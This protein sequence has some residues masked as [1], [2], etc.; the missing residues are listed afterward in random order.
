M[1]QPTRTGRR[2]AQ[3]GEGAAVEMLYRRPR[4]TARSHSRNPKR[5]LG[6]SRWCLISFLPLQ[7]LILGPLCWVPSHSQRL[8]GPGLASPLSPLAI[9]SLGDP[10]LFRGLIR[11]IYGE[12]GP[13]ISSPALTSFLGLWTP[14]FNC[15]LDNLTQMSKR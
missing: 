3:A 11:V 14:T 10:S 4:N 13:T 1:P 8:A 15:L 9:C 7:L 5:Q 12:E 6:H 2:P